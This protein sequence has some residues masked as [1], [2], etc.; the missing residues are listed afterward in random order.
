MRTASQRNVSN[1]IS[2]PRIEDSNHAVGKTCQNRVLILVCDAE[3]TRLLVCGAGDEA[4]ES[5]I[6][7]VGRQKDDSTVGATCNKLLARTARVLPGLC[8]KAPDFAM[9]TVLVSRRK[10]RGEIPFCDTA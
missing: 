3:S 2:V 10:T 9:V 1:H 7:I 8:S 4:L 5:E 6:V